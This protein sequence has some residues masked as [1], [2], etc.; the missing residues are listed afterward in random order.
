MGH[1]HAHFQAISS[2]RVLVLQSN[3]LHREIRCPHSPSTWQMLQN[4]DL[5]S[6]NFSGTLPVSLLASLEAVK[7]NVDFNLFMYEL[8]QLM[9]IYYQDTMGVT[10]KGLKLELVKILTIFTLIDFSANRLE[11]PIPNTLGDLK[12]L[13]FLNL[14][15][16]AISGS[17][18]PVLGNLDQPESLGLSWN[19]L[20]G[21]ILAQLANLHFLSFLNLSKNRLVG[22]IPTSQQFLTFF[23]S[24]LE[25][26]LRLRGLPLNKSCS[27][28]T[29][30]TEE[31]SSVP[32]QSNIDDDE[33]ND[34]SKK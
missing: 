16:N 13:Y 28:T 29:N 14:L 32:T 22:S 31:A 10:F 11:G 8:F 3:K 26:N 34:D 7:A 17:I 19:Y 24:S 25:G 12:A 5:S 15:H 2:L 21:T 23:E 4:I 18:P 20:N 1:F 30:G 9:D 6:N 27:T 33:D